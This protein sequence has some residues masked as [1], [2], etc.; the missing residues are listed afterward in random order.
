[1]EVGG[2]NCIFVL[3]RAKQNACG[4]K[5]YT[6][7]FIPTGFLTPATFELMQHYFNPFS[8]KDFVL[9]VL[10]LFLFLFLFC[11][12]FCFSPPDDRLAK[13]LARKN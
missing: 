1:M 6:S 8:S 9:Q 11:F 7:R 12:L 10:L 3:F 4:R 2:D 5:A 13:R